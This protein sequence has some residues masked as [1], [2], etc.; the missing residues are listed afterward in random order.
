[1]WRI[2]NP[3]IDKR[4]SD[5]LD[6]IHGGRL[7]PIIKLL[8]YWNEHKNEMLLSSY[9]VEVMAWYIFGN[10][11]SLTKDYGVAIRYFFNNV[12]RLLLA[13][14]PDPKGLGDKIDAY[15]DPIKKLRAVENA[16]S[17]AVKL[18]SGNLLGDSKQIDRVYIWQK[19]LDQR[20]GK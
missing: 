6:K 13:P 20:F 2:T 12:P 4:V 10:D 17:A 19:V 18:D 14:C 5:T 7:K 8:K 11:S 16:R 15:L 3:K 9:H 1:M